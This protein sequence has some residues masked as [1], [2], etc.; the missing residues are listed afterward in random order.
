MTPIPEALIAATTSSS[1]CV[2]VSIVSVLEPPVAV[3]IVNVPLVI[4]VCVF[5]AER[6]AADCTSAPPMPNVCA[7][8]VAV[9][10]VYVPFVAGF[11]GTGAISLLDWGF[12]LLAAVVFLALRELQRVLGFSRV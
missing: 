7:P 3:A 4:A 10:I 12:V 11:F 5:A 9:A 8:P 2:A 1:D 6:S